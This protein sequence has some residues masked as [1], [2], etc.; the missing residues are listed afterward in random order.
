MKMDISKMCEIVPVT[1]PNDPNAR[2][3]EYGLR[4]DENLKC[5]PA[6]PLE[7]LL[8]SRLLLLLVLSCSSP[9]VPHIRTIPPYQSGFRPRNSFVCLQDKQEANK[10]PVKA[11]SIWQ[12]QQK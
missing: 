12:G 8:F 1:N 7:L 11:Q 2:K 5:P 4:P 10:K 6:L 9:A 3:N